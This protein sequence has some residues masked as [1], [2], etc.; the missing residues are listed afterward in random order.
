MAEPTNVASEKKMRC[1]R[2]RFRIAQIAS[3]E[4]FS[5]EAKEAREDEDEK[6]G[7]GQGQERSSNSKL[8]TAIYRI[9]NQ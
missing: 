9:S 2:T 6:E 8:L 3:Q 5:G 1:A 4:A 7:R